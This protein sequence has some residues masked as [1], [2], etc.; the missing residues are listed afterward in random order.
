MCPKGMAEADALPPG[1][2]Y[3]RSSAIRIGTDQ[4]VRP[5]ETLIEA[6][7]V[8]SKG[9]RRGLPAAHGLARMAGPGPASAAGL[10]SAAGPGIFG[11]RKL[12]TIERI[13]S[14]ASRCASRSNPR[15]DLIS[16]FLVV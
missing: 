6:F 3:A 14:R 9:E 11:I 10:R 13:E 16:V 1:V 8:R 12:L 7:P 4:T 15:M 5:G 2:E